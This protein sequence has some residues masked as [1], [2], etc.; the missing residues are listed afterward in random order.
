MAYSS[1]LPD[2][3]R[4]LH[5]RIVEGL[6]VLTGEWSAEQVN[7]MALAKKLAM[8]PLHAYCYQGL[9]TLHAKIDRPD[10]TCAELANPIEPDRGLEMTFW[11]PCAEA[12][13]PRI[14]GS[15]IWQKAGCGGASTPY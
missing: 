15:G 7:R 2:R 13:L 4:T 9:T 5:A 10:Q 8:C 6:A 14:G 1:L 12:A 11:L 3:G